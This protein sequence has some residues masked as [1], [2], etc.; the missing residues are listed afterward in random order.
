M[1][2]LRHATADRS[3]I[4]FSRHIQPTAGG[5][6]AAGEQCVS[7]YKV[8]GKTVTA[9]KYMQMLATLGIL[10]KLKNFLVFQVPLPLA[11]ACDSP[12]GSVAA[13][14]AALCNPL[15]MVQLCLQVCSAAGSSTVDGHGWSQSVAL[16]LAVWYASATSRL[17]RRT[18]WQGKD[19]SAA[20]SSSKQ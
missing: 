2:P 20:A 16:H 14:V 10:V 4:A 1:S 17:P 3:P 7:V 11:A 18:V 19:S 6:A 15:S 13:R 8:D 5:A 9:D 12:V